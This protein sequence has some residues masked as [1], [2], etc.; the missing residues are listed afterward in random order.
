MN[1]Y[2]DIWDCYARMLLIRRFEEAVERLF[3]EGHIVG[4]A[5]VCIGQEAVAVGVAR[6]M[7]A[8]DALTSTHRGHGHFLALGGDPGRMMAEM[9]GKVTGYALG[10]GGSQMMSDPSGGFY[11]ANGI[12]AGSMAFAAG[13]ALAAKLQHSERVVI[14]NIGDGAS[15]QGMFHEVLNLA[16][17]WKLPL[18]LIC[19]NNRY[20]MSTAIANGL[21]NTSLAARGASY[22]L[23]SQAID[24]NDVEAVYNAVAVVLARIRSTQTPEFIECLTYRLSGHSKGDRRLYRTAAE[25]STAWQAEPLLRLEKH[26]CANFADAA[27]RLA[28]AQRVAAERIATAIAFAQNSDDPDPATVAQGVYAIGDT[29]HVVGAQV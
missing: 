4:T 16:A 1:I 28:Q 2:H 18:L 12:T 10:R 19:E 29:A 22:G 17:L 15:N 7:R 27:D 23:K 24:G 21:A 13:L 8:G 14:C 3:A 9:F 5:H 26:L 11:G 20:A 6:A 25:E